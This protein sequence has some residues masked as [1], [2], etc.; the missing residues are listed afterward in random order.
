MKMKM[1]LTSK[2][3]L[4][5]DDF[6]CLDEDD[7]QSYVSGSDD[8]LASDPDFAESGYLTCPKS[9]VPRFSAGFII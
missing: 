3:V 7:F 6:E 2:R 8:D 9:G 5:H 4:L 1:K